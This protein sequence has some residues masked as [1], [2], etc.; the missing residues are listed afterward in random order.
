MAGSI[1][2][3]SKIGLLEGSR[4]RSFFTAKTVTAVY[5][6][7][8]GHACGVLISALVKIIRAGWRVKLKQGIVRKH[9]AR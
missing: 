4:Y 9:A 5:H 6:E 7:T 8:E 1:F 2:A 3:I